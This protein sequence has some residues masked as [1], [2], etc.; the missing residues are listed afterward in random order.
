MQSLASV[1]KGC[2]DLL[3][4]RNGQN[5]LIEVKDGSRRPSER[6]LTEDQ[7]EWHQEWRG[8]VAVAESAEEALRL[9]DESLPERSATTS[10]PSAHEQTTERP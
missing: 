10:P 4:G 6:R 9:L 1:G 5:Y 3:V 8:Q 7:Q 2:P